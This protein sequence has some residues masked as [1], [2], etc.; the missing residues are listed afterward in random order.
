VLQ[1]IILNELPDQNVRQRLKR[2]SWRDRALHLVHVDHPLHVAALNVTVQ[3]QLPDFRT[4][5]YEF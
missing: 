5:T 2:Y 4:G 1:T 3:P